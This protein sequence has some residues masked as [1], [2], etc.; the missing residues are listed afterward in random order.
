[1]KK[2]ISVVLSLLMVCITALPAFSAEFNDIKFTTDKEQIENVL[3]DKGIYEEGEDV[4]TVIEYSIHNSG[5]GQPNSNSDNSQYKSSEFNVIIDKEQIED[6]LKDKGIYEEGEDVVTVIEYKTKDSSDRQPIL[7]ND[8]Y[9]KKIGTS[10]LV[11][12][13]AKYNNNYPG[14]SFKL[15]SQ[16]NVGWKINNTL[17]YQ[18]RYF[19]L[20]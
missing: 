19:H 9:S 15:R 11:D 14:G 12:S 10:T 17:G 1:M 6:V 13:T 7:G 20:L 4:V 8:F 5:N 16:I 2:L 18:L 3:K